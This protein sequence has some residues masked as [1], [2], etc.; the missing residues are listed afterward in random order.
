MVTVL[1]HFQ[2]DI[3]DVFFFHQPF[4]EGAG[5][6]GEVPVLAETACE[7]AADSA[8]GKDLRAGQ[9]MIQGFLLDRVYIY[10]GGFSVDEQVKLTFFVLAH[11]AY[12]GPTGLDYAPDLTGG[13]ADG[14]FIQWFI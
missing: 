14:F 2:F 4:A 1:L 3:F 9:E 7:I 11:P 6:L 12:A 8:D 5:E 10:G 13:T